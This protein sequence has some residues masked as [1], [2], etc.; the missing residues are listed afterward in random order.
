MKKTTLIIAVAAFALISGMKA[1][2]MITA[3]RAEAQPISLPDFKMP[4]SSGQERSIK[5]WQGKILIINF[6]ATWCPPC[7]KEMPAFEAMQQ[8]FGNKGVQFIGIALDDPEPVK[9]FINK[10]KITYPILIGQDSGTK[11]AHDLGNVI[12]TVP[13]TVIFDKKGQLLK[14]QMGTLDRE[15]LLEIIKP[16]L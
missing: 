2:T 5:E 3:A 7:M 11:I 8:E 1:R 4:D 15:Q 14:R 13:F 12:N 6:W 16:L 10:K 9:E